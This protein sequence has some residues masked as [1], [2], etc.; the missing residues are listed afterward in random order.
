MERARTVTP[1][2]KTVILDEST[3]SQRVSEMAREIAEDY[4]DQDLLLVGILRGAFI[5]LCDL[6][7]Q[8]PSSVSFDFMGISRYSPKP[9]TGEVKITKDLQE[10]LA[11]KHVLLV[12]DIVDT[13]L[14]LRYLV[15]TVKSRDP[16]SLAVCTLLD[17]PDLRLAEIPLRYVGFNVSHEFLVGYGLDYRDKYRELPFIATMDLERSGGGTAPD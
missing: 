3:I 8:I 2:V 7:R 11:G 16:A 17:R 12:E 10:D 9:A 5:F 4:R 1:A 14:T 13:G 6:V 15:R